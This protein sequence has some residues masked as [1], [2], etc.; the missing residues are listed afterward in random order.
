MKCIYLI[1]L[2]FVLPAQGQEK[3]APK[4]PPLPKLQIYFPQKPIPVIIDNKATL[5]FE[6][7]FSNTGADSVELLGFSLLDA[8]KRN[9]ILDYDSSELAGR[10]RNITPTAARN[11]GNIIAPGSTHILYI[12]AST[13]A[14]KFPEL[15]FSYQ[16]GI[17]GEKSF[18]LIKKAKKLFIDRSAPVVLSSPLQGGNWAAIHDP[19]WER[20]H[21]RV[22]YTVDGV[23]R[24]PGRFA[25]DFMKLDSVHYVQGNEDSI[26]NWLG[27]AQPVLAA[28][29]G[30]IAS[31]RNDFPE[32]STLSA[33]PDYKPEQATGNY[34]S[35]KIADNRFVF[36][37]H[38]KPGSITVKPGQSVKKGEVIALLGFTG[39]TTGPHLHFHV[40]D[41]DSP[42]GAEGLPFVFEHFIQIGHYPD[43]SKF[44]K[45]KFAPVA[46]RKVKHEMPASNSVIVFR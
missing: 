5:L 19:S 16:T 42:L 15:L 36:Y 45:E 13:N 25:I 46:A 10:L 26:Y 40:A 20:G 44:G 14:K 31:V 18:S 22:V 43:F 6:V 17:A 2:C 21:R 12:E 39:Q 11:Y 38:L 1:L 3:A 41:K 27:Y 9:R 7:Y 8:K 30:I 33:H 24:I 37:E 28:A 23:K 4:P 29:D 34:I 32:S 35:L